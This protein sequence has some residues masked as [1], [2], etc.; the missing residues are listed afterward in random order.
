MIKTEAAQKEIAK[1]VRKKSAATCM[2]AVKKLPKKLLPIGMFVLR[3]TETGKSFNYWDADKL[4]PEKSLA[5]DRL[6]K[7]DRAKIIRCFAPSL[8]TEI[9]RAYQFCI[10]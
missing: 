10:V 2:A 7:A 9:E 1:H 3:K 4:R 5:L 6:S 8:S